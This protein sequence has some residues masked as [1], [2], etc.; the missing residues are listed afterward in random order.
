MIARKRPAWVEDLKPTNGDRRGRSEGSKKTQFQPGNKAGG[1]KRHADVWELLE[2][3]AAIAT[4]R[5]RKDGNGETA[6]VLTSEEMIASLIETVRRTDPATALRV[7][8]PHIVPK[9]QFKP[10]KIE[11]DFDDLEGTLQRIATEMANGGDLA[12]LNALFNTVKTVQEARAMAL[13][14]RLSEK[15]LSE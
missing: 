3:A 10:V 2:R 12:S 8:I 1:R 9:A 5:A 13:E 7:M 15:E 14:I 4:E 11:V 6:D